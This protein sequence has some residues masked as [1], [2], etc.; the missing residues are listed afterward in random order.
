MYIGLDVHAQIPD[1]R[2]HFMVYTTSI[3]S[4]FFIPIHLSHPTPT[5]ENT[6]TVVK[7]RSKRR[8]FQVALAGKR[9]EVTRGNGEFYDLQ[10]F[11]FQHNIKPE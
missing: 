9:S 8:S 2:A 4:D 6:C 7:M 1:M 10:R 3:L 5:P 11:I